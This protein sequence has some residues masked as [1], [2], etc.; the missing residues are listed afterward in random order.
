MVFCINFD[1]L[2]V[3]SQENLFSWIKSEEMFFK[4]VE[5][6]TNFIKFHKLKETNLNEQIWIWNHHKG[7]SRL[8][9]KFKVSI[10]CGFW[11]VH[12]DDINNI[13][14]TELNG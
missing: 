2:K 3:L 6:L 12:V 11:Q 1:F 8:V 5:T 10:F 7:K 14:E 9:L 4:R 13:D